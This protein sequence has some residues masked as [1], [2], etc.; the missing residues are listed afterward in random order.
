MLTTQTHSEEELSDAALVIASLKGNRNA[1]GRIIER[2]QRLLCSLAYASMGNVSASEDVAQEAFIEGWKKLSSLREPEKL[3]AWLCGILRFKVSRHLRKQSKEPS[4]QAHSLES[5]GMTETE[6]DSIEEQ[7]MRLE[8]QKLLWNT[9]QQIPASYREPL[10][11]YYREHQSLRH[12]AAELELTEDAVKQRLSR[13][14]A[15]LRDRMTSF[16]EDALVRSTPGKVFTMAVLAALPSLA[17]TAKAM[18]MGAAIAHTSSVAKGLGIAALLASISG[19]IGSFFMVRANLDQSRTDRERKQ[20][21]WTTIFFI[22]SSLSFIALLVGMMFLAIYVPSTAPVLAV[23]SQVLILLFVLAWP[24]A[25]FRMLKR[26]SEVRAQERIRQPDA[27]EDPRD[28]VGSAAREYRSKWKLFGLPLMHLQFSVKERGEGP[29]VGWIAFGDTAYG[30]LF[31]FGGFAVG[32]ISVGLVSAG[33]LTCSVV[34]VGVIGMGTI[35]IG[36]LG[37]GA[38]AI[39]YKAYASVSALGLQSAW[40][41]GFAIARDAAVG[42]VAYARQVNNEVAAQIASLQQ[43]EQYHVYVLWALSVLVIVPVFFYAQAIR[44][45]MR[46]PR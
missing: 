35:G 45:R 26:N 17:P 44:R 19:L 33:F 27:F 28:Q 6:D 13:G 46:K 30:V 4:T 21:I 18:S 38:I 9:L 3:R 29:A 23:V 39:G 10:I 20:V 8:E 32:G 22:G 1:Y 14:R 15:L 37:L 5:I 42:P 41:P 25:T 2:Y 12:V 7:T 34:G 24:V 36:L 16:V 40:G 43:V 11:L 31:A